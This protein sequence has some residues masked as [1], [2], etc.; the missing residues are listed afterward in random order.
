MTPE[1]PQND[2]KK[3]SAEELIA[4]LDKTMDERNMPRG[5]EQVTVALIELVEEGKVR[6]FLKPNG[7]INYQYNLDLEGIVKK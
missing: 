2:W 5:Y 6:A 3:L 1:I 7:E 4:E